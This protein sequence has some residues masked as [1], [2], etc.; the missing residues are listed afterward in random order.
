MI[1]YISLEWQEYAT[2]GTIRGLIKEYN[3][4]S[5]MINKISLFLD[6]AIKKLISNSVDGIPK[7]S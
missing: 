2:T 6:T 3:L 4:S 1:S 5:I 7:G